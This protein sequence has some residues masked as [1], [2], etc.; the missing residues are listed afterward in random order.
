MNNNEIE[1]Q[2]LEQLIVNILDTLSAFIKWVIF[3]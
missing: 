3:E 2:Q 1:I